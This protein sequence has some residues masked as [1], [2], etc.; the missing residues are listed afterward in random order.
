MNH[1]HFCISYVQRHSLPCSALS[2]PGCFY[3]KQSWKIEIVSF[4]G[5]KTVFIAHL[6][7]N[8]HL[9]LSETYCVYKCF[10]AFVGSPM[11]I[12]NQGTSFRK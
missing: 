11:G 2:F 4:S 12:G 5:A 9:R 10:L 3:G 1:S 7:K 8:G 6:K